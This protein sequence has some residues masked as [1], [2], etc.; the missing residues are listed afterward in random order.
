MDGVTERGGGNKNR[1]CS[2][3]LRRAGFNKV[4]IVM[5]SSTATRKKKSSKKYLKSHF[6]G[7]RSGHKQKNKIKWIEHP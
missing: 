2:K 6:S 7:R 3:G 1:L 5:Q 4:L